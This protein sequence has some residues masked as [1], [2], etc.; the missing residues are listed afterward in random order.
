MP[1]I[2]ERDLRRLA[3]RGGVADYELDLT[4]VGAEHARLA[5][6]RM[7]ERQRFRD[8]ARSVVIR[9]DPAGPDSGETLFQPVGRQLL[10]AMKQGLVARCSPIPPEAGAGFYVELPGRAEAADEG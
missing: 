3:G 7:L 5:I 1:Y 10:A 8:E 2:E 6:E 9:L 4:G